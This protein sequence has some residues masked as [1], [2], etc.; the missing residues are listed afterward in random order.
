MKTLKKLL[1]IFSFFMISIGISFSQ[2]IDR[3]DYQSSVEFKIKNLGFEVDGRFNEAV[4]NIN[5]DENDISKSSFSGNVSVESIDTDNNKRDKH[6]RK[7]AYFDAKNYPKISFE[8]SQ[9]I[10]IS[11]ENYNITGRL[12]IKDIS[13]QIT[14][15]LKTMR[16]QAGLELSTYFEI[17]RLDYKIGDNS[18][19]LSDTVKITITYLQK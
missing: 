10:R 2:K 19:V 17:D 13:K 7:E 14:I 15:P 6:L 11:K 1:Y 12:T 4:F 8:S 3:E 5:F 9:I 18:L 16:T